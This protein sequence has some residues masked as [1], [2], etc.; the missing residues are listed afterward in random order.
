MLKGLRS[1]CL[2]LGKYADDFR[3]NLYFSLKWIK[4]KQWQV[5]NT[6]KAKEGKIWHLKMHGEVVINNGIYKEIKS[7]F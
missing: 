5:V 2:K 1:E 7:K 4:M 6:K 3:L